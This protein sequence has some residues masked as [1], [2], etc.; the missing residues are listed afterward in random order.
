M[1][2]A[3]NSTRFPKRDYSNMS[4][5]QLINLHEQLIQS[6]NKGTNVYEHLT[7][8]ELEMRNRGLDY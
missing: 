5:V 4:D 3:S 7:D 1:T 8:I 6:Y 2:Y